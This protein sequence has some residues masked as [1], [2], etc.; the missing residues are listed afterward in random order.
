MLKHLVPMALAACLALPF[1]A[2][3][4]FPDGPVTIVVPSKAGGSTDTTARL[5]IQ[6][7]KKFWPNAE[8]V[9]KNVGGPAA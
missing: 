5:F 9:V 1:T 4:A 3:A 2:Q 8:F 7:A 6:S